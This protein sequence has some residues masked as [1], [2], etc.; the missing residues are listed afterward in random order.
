MLSS[1]EIVE[2]L[3]SAK[4]WQEKRL[5]INGLQISQASDPMVIQALIE[6]AL[7]GEHKILQRAAVRRLGEIRDPTAVEP[8]IIVFQKSVPSVRFAAVRA[9]GQIRDAEAVE[10][11]VAVLE[12]EAEEKSVREAAAEALGKIAND[13]AVRALVAALEDENVSIQDKASLVLVEVGASAVEPLIAALSAEN[14]AT[15]QRATVTL[16]EIGG[17]EGYRA[18]HCSIGR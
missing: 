6:V 15:R 16:G 13:R 1:E 8:L 10:F 18:A 12:D 9:L 4:T 11:L 7:K 14:I 2:K 3:Q 5:L 17:Q